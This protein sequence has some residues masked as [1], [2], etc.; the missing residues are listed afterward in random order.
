[1][2]RVEQLP[3]DA[4]DAH[5]QGEEGRYRNGMTDDKEAGMALRRLGGI[6]MGYHSAMWVLPNDQDVRVVSYF[7]ERPG[8]ATSTVGR[9]GLDG[10]DIH[11][12]PEAWNGGVGMLPN[13]RENKENMHRIQACAMASQWRRQ[14][15]GDFASYC[16]FSEGPSAHPLGLCSSPSGNPSE[17][18][19][20]L[21]V[22]ITGWAHP[23][24]FW[25]I[26]LR[27]PFERTWITFD[28][29]SD[30]KKHFSEVFGHLWAKRAV[31][32][33]RTYMQRDTRHPSTQIF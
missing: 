24:H 16:M 5:G 7:T 9:A 2:Q 20:K 21:V 26:D 30:D 10:R 11:S 17:I 14:L 18:L 6:P 32:G 25:V 3:K 29:L 31:A 4:Q 1:M 8:L 23:C 13:E 19:A 15:G 12:V 28:S 33:F 27:P 22:W